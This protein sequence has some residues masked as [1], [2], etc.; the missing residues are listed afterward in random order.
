VQARKKLVLPSDVAAVDDAL[1]DQCAGAWNLACL[2]QRIQIDQIEEIALRMTAA[3]FLHPRHD[4]LELAH[5]LRMLAE[6]SRRSSTLVG[7]KGVFWAAFWHRGLEK[8]IA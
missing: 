3:H 6:A 1:F 4:G 7:E 2:L 5:R 8:S